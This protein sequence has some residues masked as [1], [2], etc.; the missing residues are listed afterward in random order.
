MRSLMK[1]HIQVE[2]ALIVV[3]Q[4]ERTAFGFS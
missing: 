2:N 3:A 1:A 4:V